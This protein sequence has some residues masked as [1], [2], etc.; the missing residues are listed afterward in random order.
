MLDGAPL[1]SVQE[2]VHL[3]DAIIA[4]ANE[5]ESTSKGAD[6]CER[7]EAGV[8]LCFTNG[9]KSSHCIGPHH[10][11]VVTNR[12]SRAE[13][14]GEAKDARI[15]C[16]E[17]CKQSECQDRSAHRLSNV[18]ALC[19]RGNGIPPASTRGAQ[20]MSRAEGAT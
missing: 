8:V 9:E 2:E 10:G 7:E 16:Q 14:F 20:S 5:A 13:I 15:G 11:E 1:G 18:M 6:A 19:R 3:G 4:G 12:D 17:S